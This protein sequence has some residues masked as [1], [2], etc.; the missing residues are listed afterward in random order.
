MKKILI[1]LLIIIFAFEGVGCRMIDERKKQTRKEIVCE[2]EE[3]INEKYENVGYSFVAFHPA[4]W[5]HSYDL[6]YLNTEFEGE[7][8]D[9]CVKRYLKNGKYVFEDN[10]F[11]LLITK[12]FVSEINKFA[13]KYFKQ[14]IADANCTELDYPHSFTKNSTLEDLVKKKDELNSITFVLIVNQTFANTED[15]KVAAKKFCDDW[16]S[17]GI[18]SNA[19]VIYVSNSVYETVDIKNYDSFRSVLIDN[20]IYE[21]FETFK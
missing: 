17:V 13:S 6:L 3:Y 19:R 16:K 18:K 12:D 11:G 20:R 4:G 21:Y 14:F 15:F 10:Y 8:E 2:M 9:F 1:S 7:Q 5:D